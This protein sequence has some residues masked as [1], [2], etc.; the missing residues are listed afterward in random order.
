MTAEKA[1]DAEAA[2]VLTLNRKL[3]TAFEEDYEFY[4][5]TLESS[6]LAEQ[7]DWHVDELPEDLE[8]FSIK[9]KGQSGKVLSESPQT[10][11][12]Y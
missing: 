11:C 12:M 8:D 3:F 6:R 4:L 2:E 7:P 1:S 9:P 5:P 10:R